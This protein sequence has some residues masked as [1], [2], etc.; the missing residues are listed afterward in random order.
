MEKRGVLGCE[1]I[2]SQNNIWRGRLETERGRNA[3]N[4]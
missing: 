3:T 1:Q 4:H 2:I